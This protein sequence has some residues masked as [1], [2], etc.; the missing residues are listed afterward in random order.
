MLQVGDDLLPTEEF[1]RT[2]D[3][4]TA[5]L[6]QKHPMYVCGIHKNV[7]WIAF[8]GSD[9]VVGAYLETAEAMRQAYLDM[10]QAYLDNQLG[11]SQ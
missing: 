7:A 9:V 1:L 11:G 8:L 6:C 10:R 5:A 4:H 2:H 3:R